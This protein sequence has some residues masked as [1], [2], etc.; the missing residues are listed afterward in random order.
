MTEKKPFK[1]SKLV[2]VTSLGLNLVVVGLVAGAW[3]NGPKRGDRGGAAPASWD[4]GPF[5]RALS[6][7]DRRMMG[8]VFRKDPEVR[9]RLGQRRGEMRRIGFEIAGVL[10]TDP[11]DPLALEALFAKQ[12]QLGVDLQQIGRG[13]L[14]DRITA[15]T[16]EDRLDFADRLEEGMKR[17]P[18]RNKE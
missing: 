18:R 4:A 12:A 17:R 15:M 8:D 10:R 13:A 5:G 6:R 14:L 1:W 9:E 3:V 2:L 7:Q 16:P 11:F